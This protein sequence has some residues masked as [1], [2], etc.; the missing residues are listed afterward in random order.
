MAMGVPVARYKILAFAVSG[1]LTGTAGAL[2][3]MVQPYPYVDSRSFTIALS[4]ALVTGLVVGGARSVAGAALAGLFLDRVPSL[5]EDVAHLDGSATNVFYG[6][7]LILMM[8]VLPGGI[9]GGVAVLRRRLTT[10]LGGA[11]PPQADPATEPRTAEPHD[12]P[13]EAILAEH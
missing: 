5:V 13:S 11:P 9:A 2:S 7:L 12:V 8:F 1:A 4:I 3:V 10:R 6:G